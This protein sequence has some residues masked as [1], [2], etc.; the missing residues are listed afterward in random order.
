[1]QQCNVPSADTACVYSD[2]M[3]DVDVGA[4]VPADIDHLCRKRKR[5]VSPRKEV[6]AR[7]DIAEFTEKERTAGGR[8][9]AA[10]LSCSGLNKIVAEYDNYLDYP[11]WKYV[12][13]IIFSGLCIDAL[14]QVVP[15]PY[16]EVWSKLLAGVRQ[17][18]KVAILLTLTSHPQAY[19]PEFMTSLFSQ[20]MFDGLLVSF[21]A[22]PKPH[23][24]EACDSLRKFYVV[25]KD[26]TQIWLAISN[27]PGFYSAVDISDMY[28]LC[29]QLVVDSFGY[30]KTIKQTVDVR[31]RPA[32]TLNDSQH[33]ESYMESALA[34][35]TM[36]VAKLDD[37]TW[38]F[39]ELC[40]QLLMGIDTCGVK[41]LD[42]QRTTMA[43]VPLHEIKR[44]LAVGEK[45]GDRTYRYK[46]LYSCFDKGSLLKLPGD[47][48]IISYD[49]HRVRVQKILEARKCAGVVLGD[50]VH[51]IHPLHPDSLLKMS[52]DRFVKMSLRKSL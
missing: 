22:V 5:K 43:A 31:D 34:D 39:K 11:G 13:H 25:H 30:S 8:V 52:Y 33:D 16:P 40:G 29:D 2:D 15:L 51:D 18:Y 47:R 14:G 32:L 42:G 45:I 36:T 37:H 20:T 38:R 49:N 10:Y 6:T 46:S 41:Y 27:V 44:L 35:W 9:I 26:S 4:A 3:V 23:V 12:T 24:E 48:Q 7:V 1:M 17:K 21:V 28:M 50:L 19:T